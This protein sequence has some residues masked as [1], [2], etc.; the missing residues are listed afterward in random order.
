MTL[1]T[2]IKSLCIGV[3]FC[4][5]I[6][7]VFVVNAATTVPESTPILTTPTSIIDNIPEPLQQWI[8]WVLKDSPSL[9]CPILYNQNNHYCAYANV[10]TIEMNAES[11]KF[12]QTWDV[13]A[14][15]WIYLPGDTKNW[16]KNVRVNNKTMPVIDRN[17][18]PSM[19]LQ[20]GHH[21]IN[22]E[23]SWKQKPKSLSI[24]RETGLVKLSINNKEIHLPDIRAGKLWL[25]TT[26]TSAHQNNRLNLR[27][28]RKI[29]DTIPLRVTT[30][31]KLDVSGL[32][33]EI[34]LNGAILQGFSPSA[35]NSR[36]PSQLDVNG[37]LKVQIRPGQWTI[38]I[39]S[40]NPQQL[41]TINLPSFERP[42]PSSEI[43]V[44]DQQTQLRLIKVVGKNSIDSNQTLLP[45]N[46]KTYPAYSMQGAEQ[47]KFD[48][49]KRGNSD[50]EPDQLTLT[51]RI[52][53]DFD[54]NGFT[55][56][57]KL[58][59]TL[60]KQWRLNASSDVTLGQ[61][62]LN[63]KPQFITKDSNGKQGVEVRHGIL[64]LSADSRIDSNIRT[65]SS[66]GWDMDF[67]DAS[68]TLY[69]PAGWDLLSLS[70][71]NVNTSWISKWSLLDLFMV[72]ITA[73]AIYKLW[74]I[75]WGAIGLVTLVFVWH[76]FNSPQYIWIN[77]IIA[78]AILRSLPG[79][80]FR[81][82]VTGY[83]LITSVVLLLIVLPFIVNQARTALYPQLEFNNMSAGNASYV[84][85]TL[86]M[87]SSMATAQTARKMES[88]AIEDD[89]ERR[90]IEGRSIASYAERNK[91]KQMISIDSDAIIQTGP[92]LPA[93]TLH[94]YHL[95]W[96][97][98]VRQDQTISIIL[99][100]PAMNSF[101]N[102]LRIALVLLLAWRL[103]DIASLKMPKLTFSSKNG[104]TVQSILSVFVI[105]SVLSLL[106][107]M[108]E[109]AYPP[110]KM[111]D[112]L[113]AELSKTP[114]CLPQCASIETLSIDLSENKLSLRLRIHAQRDVLVPL[115]VPIKQWVPTNVRVDDKQSAILFRKNDSTLWINLTKGTHTVRF[116]GRVNSLNQLQFSFPLKPHYVEL[117]INGWATEGMDT[118]AYKIT[119]LS[120][121]RIVDKNSGI[122][123]NKPEQKE[124]PV[125][126]EVTRS[127]E[128][129]LDWQVTTTVQGIFGT[130]YPI[131]L[132][133]PLL[134]GESV[135][136]DNIKIKNARA[137]ITLSQ[138]N[139]SIQWI[140][141]LKVSN[142]INLQASE[143]GTFTEKWSLNASAIW[144]I[145]YEG[146]PVIYHQR[147][148]NQWQPEWQPW[149]GEKVSIAISRP[150][151][152][153]GNTITIDS[154]ILAFAPGE[155]ITAAKLIFNLRSSQGGQH[156]INIPK[157]AE[158]QTVIING[159]SMPV[160]QTSEGIA[161]PI[162]P[163]KQ[164]VELEWREPHGITSIYNSSVVN[165]GSDSVNHTLQI[166]PGY[167]RWVLF[168]SGPMMGPAVL[169]WGVLGVILII[170]YGL[171][172][173][174][175]T[176]L[177]TRQWLLL[178]VGLSASEPW[179][180][181]IIA[182]CILALKARGS[183]NLETL[184]NSKFNLFQTMLVGLVFISVS[185]LIIAIQQGLLGSPDMQ[186]IG[187]GSS[188]YQLNWF[189]DRIT[190]ITP[191]SMMI[192][193]PV[194]VYR[195]IMLIW[196]IWLAFA[197]IKWARWGWGNF[198]K[199]EYWRSVSFKK[200]PLKVKENDTK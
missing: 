30:Q 170:A 79:G 128:L 7:A 28:F 36:L 140:S 130:A 118:D 111:L 95:R 76:E 131:V 157:D 32:Q 188:A 96:D 159:Q 122:A 64:N 183:I 97:G 57:D 193:V 83:R 54:G 112:A 87:T 5:V 161:L 165:L 26:N 11:G 8:S 80:R 10:L 101:L 44:L 85:N 73:I 119:V 3:L 102:M 84:Q 39:R 63:E 173:I 4:V 151:G 34:I 71:A 78:V 88:L 45:Q 56:N 195:L 74:G 68:A 144:H 134:E 146:I 41:D 192:S 49:I 182:V 81:K 17:N 174:K 189:S 2:R 125:Y 171:G 162:S 103:L 166:K 75:P 149:P 108:V 114:V 109:A 164:K 190:K 110:Q 18:K 12:Q 69:L 52:W 132:E 105:G 99:L 150:S 176:P 106:P 77:L 37:R 31:I 90:S 23:F 133:I 153:K 15:S 152:V 25:K 168:T 62:T 181:V 186:I 124:I 127:I 24:P 120:F 184:S 27:V 156:S 47:L 163:G 58:T 138:S 21:L 9:R 46:W 172:R 107:T 86:P 126:A 92:G 121:L 60:S 1:G 175:E 35:I 40:F 136:T 13:F 169:F 160:R 65:F 33:R 180:V 55:V 147:H 158:L 116:S 82:F 142:Q 6:S 20:K 115:P 93:W 70:G 66:S 123:V 179:A 196:S 185:T 104:A 145:D 53:L 199:Q 167:N 72:L 16:P 198:T 135:V 43:W 155:Q 50:P 67:R 14:E 22:G 91:L 59:G 143:Q 113:K 38:E 137:V 197:L 129:G 141:K 200:K 194:S 117:N 48:V 61:V 177:N 89:M 139:R 19:R 187:N 154:S 191:D 178:A 98:P 94:Q 29:S 100:S 42:W 148:A 51:K